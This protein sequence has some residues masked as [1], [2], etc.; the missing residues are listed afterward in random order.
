VPAP[1]RTALV[2]GAGVVAAGLVLADISNSKHSCEVL[3]PGS[4]VVQY[5]G[6]PV[7]SAGVYQPCP[8]TT[9]P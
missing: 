7:V 3:V 5:A 8:T 6:G 9:G 4:Q 1:A 2:V